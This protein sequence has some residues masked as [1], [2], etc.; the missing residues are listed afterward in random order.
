MENLEKLVEALKNLDDESLYHLNN[1][2]AHECSIDDVLWGVLEQMAE[3][4]CLESAEFAYKVF[5]GSVQNW[6]I[7]GYYRFDGYANVEQIWKLSEH[8]PLREIAQWLI[9]QGREE[10]FLEEEGEE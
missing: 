5:F 3:D 4:A 9:E 6:N 1:D 7:D 2:W 8:L 10:E